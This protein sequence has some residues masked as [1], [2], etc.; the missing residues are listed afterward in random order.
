MSEERTRSPRCP[1][2][3]LEEAIDRAGSLYETNGKHFVAPDAAAQGLGYK[4]SR[5][6]A[7]KS[8]IASLSYYGLIRRNPDGKIAVAPEFEKFKFAPTNEVRL[9]FLGVWIK[10]PRVFALL[11]EKYPDSLPSDSALKYELIEAGF[12]PDAADEASSVFRT[13]LAYVKAQGLTSAASAGDA[14]DDIPDDEPD[15]AEKNDAAAG[16]PLTPA[17]PPAPTTVVGARAITVFLPRQREAVLYIPRPFLAKDREVIKRQLD[18]L[19]T[20]DEEDVTE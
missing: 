2:V 4:D 19:L 13:S 15:V 8:M 12:K 11:L 5:N 7:A 14:T 10:N 17:K 6:G 20:D 3:S 16:A 1:S 9:Q 18:A